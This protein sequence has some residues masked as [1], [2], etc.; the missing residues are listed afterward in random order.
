MGGR[1]ARHTQAGVWGGY[2]SNNID[3]RQVMSIRTY[4]MLYV[5]K[6]YLD[7]KN[8]TQD[9]D[10]DSIHRPEKNTTDPSRA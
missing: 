9:L 7:N 10:Q 6:S 2:F 4:Y 1:G 3:A 8:H 5:R